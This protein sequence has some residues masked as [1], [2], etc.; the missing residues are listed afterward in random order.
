MKIKHFI[1]AYAGFV[2]MSALGCFASPPVWNGTWK[3]NQSKSNIPGP[4]FSI[5]LL[6]TGEYR[7]DN[8]TYNYNFRCDG[9]EYIT[10]LSHTIS[11]VQTSV[12]EMDTTSKEDGKKV[13][14]AHWELSDDGKTLTVKGTA[15]GADGAFKAT[16]RV[17]LRTSGSSGFAGGWRD[18]KRLES[19]PQLVLALNERSLHIAFSENGQYMDPPLDGTDAPCHGPSV[20]QNLTIAIKPNGPREFLTLRKL[21]GK[22]VNQG[23]LRLSVDG[24]TLVEEYWPPSR[25]DEKA[26]LVYERQ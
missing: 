16:E 8:G 11:C 5:T 4:S 7:S 10:R 18:T 12:S 1:L 3:L 25:P 24:R 9:K 20:P 23:F 22:V 17:Y 15:T 13:G 2:W 14:T 19:R 21:D 26:T 6:P